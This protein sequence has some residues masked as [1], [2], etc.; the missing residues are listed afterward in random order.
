ME[1]RSLYKK[2]MEVSCYSWEG[3]HLLLT[4]TAIE[5]NAFFTFLCCFIVANLNKI[6]VLQI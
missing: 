4:T 5:F 3:S 1:F 6:M 2:Y